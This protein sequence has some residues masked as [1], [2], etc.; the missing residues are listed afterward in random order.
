MA[1]HGVE[2]TLDDEDEVRFGGSPSE[3]NSKKDNL[4]KKAHTA[5]EKKRRDAIRQGYD[6]LAELVPSCKDVDP[7]SSSKLSKAVIMSRTI[8]YMELIS[9]ESDKNQESL[10]KLQKDATGLKIQLGNYESIIKSH[11]VA[12]AYQSTNIADA[13]KLELF[14]RFCD[15]LFL[16]FDSEVEC[17][18]FQNLSRGMLLWSERH[19]K[20]EQLH[21]LF[22]NGVR[23]LARNDRTQ[24]RVI[25]PGPQQDHNYAKEHVYDS[26]R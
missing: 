23:D 11:H 5:A 24:I 9:K 8:D 4:R 13:T 1:L 21:H 15:E 3:D 14:Q 16:T 22:D 2:T 25:Y 18:N 12:N 26:R 7:L 19:C 6:D 20:P 17:D 10:N